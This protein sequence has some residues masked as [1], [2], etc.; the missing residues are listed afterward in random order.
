MKTLADRFW[1]KVSKRGVDECW[2]WMAFKDAQGYGKISVN[3]SPRLA[4][5]VSYEIHHG[6]IPDGMFA[7]HRCDNPGC[8]NPGHI[9]IGQPIDNIKDMHDKGRAVYPPINAGKDHGMC[10]LKPA[11]VL[12]I[13]S[14]RGIP[15]RTLAKQYGIGQSQVQRIRSGEGWPHLI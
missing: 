2:E 15:Q 13:R 12:A 3:S 9:F 7:C 8:V 11:D 14:A 10:K 5:R 6:P 1:T 4:H